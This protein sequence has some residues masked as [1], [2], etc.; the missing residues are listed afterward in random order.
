MKKQFIALALAL[1]GLLFAAPQQ[2]KAEPITVLSTQ[3]GAIL[4]QQI[5]T[6]DSVTPGTFGSN[7]TVSGLLAGDRLVGIDRRPI[8]GLI[9]GV[10]QNGTVG[11][12]YTINATTGAASLVSTLSVPLT[13]TNFGVDFNPTVD[14]LRVVSN[15][16]QNLRINVDTG[17]TLVDGTLAYAVG[18]PNQGANPNITAVAYSN[19][20]AGATTTVL[21]DMDASLDILAIQNPP[22]D[23]T[24][25]NALQLAPLVTDIGAYDISGLTGTPY[26]A[27]VDASGRFSNLYTFSMGGLTLIGRIGNLDGFLV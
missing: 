25:T 27:F 5:A 26:W 13:G 9:Y 10:A 17:A 16:D 19:N 11:R 23:G 8:N 1:T 15:L 6:F 20:F 2:A 22:N 21:R 24:L 3:T 7:I 4:S 18:D 12:I 14:R